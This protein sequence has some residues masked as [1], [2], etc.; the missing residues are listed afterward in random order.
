M[1]VNGASAN[2]ETA[3]RNPNSEEDIER[4]S[5]AEQGSE[6]SDYHPGKATLC[7]DAPFHHLT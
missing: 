6:T 4:I 1:G 5:M 3:V 2:V 7:V